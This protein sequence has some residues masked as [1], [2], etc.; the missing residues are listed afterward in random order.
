MNGDGDQ[1]DSVVSS[2]RLLDVEILTLTLYR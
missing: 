1:T 2:G